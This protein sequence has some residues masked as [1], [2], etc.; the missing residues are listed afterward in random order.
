MFHFLLC[1]LARRSLLLPIQSPK[2]R[3][4]ILFYFLLPWW[5]S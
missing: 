5:M 4:N 3:D 2:F 1:K